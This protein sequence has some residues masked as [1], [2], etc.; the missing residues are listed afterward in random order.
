IHQT[1]SPR[2]SPP[3]PTMPCQTPINDL[4][5]SS[6]YR[7]R[8]EEDLMTLQHQMPPGGY[9]SLLESQGTLHPQSG[10][11][12]TSWP[13][14]VEQSVSSHPVTSEPVKP[15]QTQE[16]RVKERLDKLEHKPKPFQDSV[17]RFTKCK[18]K[19]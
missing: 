1:I 11:P 4:S 7:P 5:S 18:K 10:Y 12:P 17:K 3:S 9:M 14:M 15:K 16:E 13:Q 8:M 19:T 6:C 2:R